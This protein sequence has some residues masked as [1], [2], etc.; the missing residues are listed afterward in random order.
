MNIILSK[1]VCFSLAKKSLPITQRHWF[2]YDQDRK[3]PALRS[4]L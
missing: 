1:A 4:G 2:G 3:G